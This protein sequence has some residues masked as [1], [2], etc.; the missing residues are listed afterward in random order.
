MPGR[1]AARKV[2]VRAA[3]P[4]DREALPRR[5]AGSS[6]LDAGTPVRGPQITP[7]IKAISF[8]RD[9]LFN[10]DKRIVFLRKHQAGWA[11]AL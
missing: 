5:I 9:S 11:T 10:C 6:D 7:A 2:Y 8:G 4:A 1:K 3:A